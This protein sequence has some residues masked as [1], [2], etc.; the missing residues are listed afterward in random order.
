VCEATA[1]LVVKL[2]RDKVRTSSLLYLLKD[3]TRRSE[4][5]L[6]LE[7]EQFDKGKERSLMEC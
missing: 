2:T 7:N 3:N 1:H 6:M 5:S 4:K